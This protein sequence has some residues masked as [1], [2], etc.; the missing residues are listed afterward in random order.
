MNIVKTVALVA[1]VIICVILILLVLVQN[2]EN[3]G[4]GSVHRLQNGVILGGGHGQ[5]LASQRFYLRN[6][7]V[8]VHSQHLV[9]V[10]T[11]GGIRRPLVKII[12]LAP[13]KVNRKLT[14]AAQKAGKR[15]KIIV[16]QMEKEKE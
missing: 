12:T 7:I 2:E 10:Q 15:R 6:Q 1:F 5:L 8:K 11:G 14:H 3:N 9:L 4:M 16:I 13:P